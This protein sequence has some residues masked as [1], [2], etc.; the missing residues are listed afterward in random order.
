MHITGYIVNGIISIYKFIAAHLTL[1]GI[2]FFIKFLALY[3]VLGLSACLL[4]FIC[5]GITE[6]ICSG[7]DLQAYFHELVRSDLI[8]FVEAF[9]ANILAGIPFGEVLDKAA[10]D[11]GGFFN[12]FATFTSGESDV[13]ELVQK[14]LFNDVVNLLVANFIIYIFCRINKTISKF[15]SGFAF[16]VGLFISMG[17]FGIAGFSISANILSIVSFYAKDYTAT[18][19]IVLAVTCFILHALCLS[20]IRDGIPILSTVRYLGTNLILN[21]LNSILIWIIC[22]NLQGLYNYEHLGALLL[23]FVLFCIVLL[24]EKIFL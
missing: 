1:K 9:K 7:T 12:I 6:L 8:A 2:F 3:L 17:I 13:W 16:S 21:I 23:G 10:E 24:L 4:T 14:N 18:A 22:S 20:R 19:Y 5:D 15:F 11:S